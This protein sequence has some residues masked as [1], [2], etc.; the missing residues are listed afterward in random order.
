MGLSLQEQLL[1]AGVVNKKQVKKAEHEKRVQGKKKKKGQ[2]SEHAGNKGKQLLQ[3]Q[4]A[5]QAKRDQQLNAERQRQEKL[6][7]ELAAARQLVE[8]NRRPL[9]SGDEVFSYVDGGK[10]RKLYV[11][12]EIAEQLASGTLAVARC[13]DDLVLLSAAIAVKVLQRD[14]STILIYNDPAADDEYPDVW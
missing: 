2:P 1:Q 9:E 14:D 5:E 4:Q 12:E 6:K 7:E 10:I 11:K 3:Q 13:R 8:Q